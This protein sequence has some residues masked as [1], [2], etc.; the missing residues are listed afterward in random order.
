[1]LI[2]FADL[3]K[4]FRGDRQ[5][6]TDAKTGRGGAHFVKIGLVANH[7]LS[8]HRN[9]E[10]DWRLPDHARAFH[11]GFNPRC[12]D[13]PESVREKKENDTGAVSQIRFVLR[14]QQD[15][16]NHGDIDRFMNGYARSKDTV[17]VS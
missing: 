13:G 15:A 10:Q 16:W 17:F 3:V 6:R 11:F 7:L 9:P 8:L 4:R 14:M 12:L 1:M 2:K 5:Q